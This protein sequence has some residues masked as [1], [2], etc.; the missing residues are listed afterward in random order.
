[1]D[2]YLG[3]QIRRLRQARG[4]NQRALA[5][6]VGVTQAQISLHEKGEDIPSPAI[7]PKYAEALGLSLEEF[8]DLIQKSQ[9]KESLRASSNLSEE[10]RRSI[11]DYI[12]FAWERDRNAR[13]ERKQREHPDGGKDARDLR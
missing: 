5:A 6:L 8:E 9:V 10:A 7:R 12:D 11:E 1:M 4:L 3:D 13:E 2:G